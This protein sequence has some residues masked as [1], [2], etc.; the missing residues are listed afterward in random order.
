M[1]CYSSTFK[2][3][4]VMSMI[5]NIIMQCAAH[6]NLGH[7]IK[8]I[9]ASTEFA[10]TEFTSTISTL[11]PTDSDVPGGIDLGMNFLYK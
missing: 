1:Q 6:L 11:F 9:N 5:V 10:S 2:H 3:S 7:K 8:V 4:V